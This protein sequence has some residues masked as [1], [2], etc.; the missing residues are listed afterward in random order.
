G[1]GR[2]DKGE[3]QAVLEVS[4]EEA[5]FGCERALAYEKVVSCT[6]CR[7][8]GAA[9][10][11]IPETCDACQGRGRVRFQQ[12]IL[13]IA[14]ERTCSRCRGTGHIVKDPCTTCRGSALV[15]STNTLAV[16]LPQGIESGTTRLVAGAG[17]KPRNDRAA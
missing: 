10:G 8:T 9:P 3:V 15:T 6:D 2:G 14:V 7:G 4:F 13:P 16:T 12:G 11:T 5:A 17:N 1:V